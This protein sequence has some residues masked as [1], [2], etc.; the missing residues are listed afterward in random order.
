MKGFSMSDFEADNIIN[1]TVADYL[2]SLAGDSPEP[3]K[4]MEEEAR[5]REFPIVGP[6]VGRFLELLVTAIDPSTI[7]ELG[8]GFGY[9]AYWFGRSLEGI[10]IHLTDTSSENLEQARRYLSSDESTNRFHYHQGDALETLERI[11]DGIDLIF[12]DI[13]K[14]DYPESLA[15]A[16]DRLASGGWLIADNVLWK[17][18]VA[19]TDVKDETTQAIRQFNRKLKGP[20]WT[21]SVLPIRDGLAIARRN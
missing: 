4:Q 18:K 20:G 11:G 13:D 8:S 1:E 17:G 14:E 16:E 6:Q 9:S 3:A 7:V 12:V 15:L 5:R 21:S 19:Q 2:G 10:D